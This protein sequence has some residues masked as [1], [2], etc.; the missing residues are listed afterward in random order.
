MFK[1]LLLGSKARTKKRSIQLVNVRVRRSV[2]RRV[3]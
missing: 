2:I 1:A 3:W